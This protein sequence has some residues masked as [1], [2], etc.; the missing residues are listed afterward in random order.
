[1]HFEEYVTGGFSIFLK[2]PILKYIRTVTSDISIAYGLVRKVSPP[3]WR[4]CRVRELLG[5]QIPVT[6]GGVKLRIS[7]IHSSYLTHWA[8]RPN[9]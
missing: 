9:S 2:F 6:T 3:M 5:S 7:C 1:M 4:W 8:V